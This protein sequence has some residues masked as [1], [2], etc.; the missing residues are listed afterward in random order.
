MGD[1]YIN[2]INI[3]YEKDKSKIK[4]SIDMSPIFKQAAKIKQPAPKYVDIDIEKQFMVDINIL[5]DCMREI[6]NYTDEQVK[7][8]V[9]SSYIPLLELTLKTNENPY[10]SMG[11]MSVFSNI[12]YIN[13]LI[14]V[15][16]TVKLDYTHRVYL[17]HI[18]YDYRTYKGKKS[19]NDIIN[20]LHTE[21]GSIV[22]ADVLL[23]LYGT[24]LDRNMLINIA[25]SKF[26][27]FDPFIC[28]K[29]VNL[30]LFNSKVPLTLQNII[31]VY[32]YLFNDSISNL[33]SGVMFDVYT[34]DDLRT[35]EEY[36]RDIYSTMSLAILELLN[37]MPSSDIM[38][39]L[40]SY[41]M[42]AR[43]R[44]IRFSLRLS[45]D[46]YRINQVIEVLNSQGIYVP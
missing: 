25:I 20:K 13:M 40:S 6:N 8:L 31:D 37:V 30:E 38:T 36:Q 16:N 34:E 35:A 19:E 23:K 46:Y 7:E 21:L 4:K 32:Q 33:F 27:S 11:I 28:V 1:N 26:S 22:N 18:L 42:S 12:R 44:N 5:F 17:N 3:E 15:L 24:G 39:I 41:S 29:R 9:L 10:Y 14:N 43:N 45:N 2:N